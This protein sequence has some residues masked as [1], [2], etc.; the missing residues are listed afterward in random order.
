MDAIFPMLYH[1]FYE[2]GLEWIGTGIQEGLAAMAQGGPI[3]PSPRQLFAGLYLPAL[4]GEKRIQ[5][6]EVAREAGAHGVSFFE[7]AGLGI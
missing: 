2:E 1:S 5:A 7:M 3:D 4:S 6:V